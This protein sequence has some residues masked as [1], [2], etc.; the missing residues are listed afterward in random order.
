MEFSG[1][2]YQNGLPFPSLGG[3]PDPGIEP[4]SPALQAD[5]L[6]CEIP[7]MPYKCTSFIVTLWTVACQ[8]PLS[9]EFSKKEYW[10]ESSFP[11]PGDLPNSWMEPVSPVSPALAGRFST[12]APPGK[13]FIWYD[14]N[15]SL[16]SEIFDM[17]FFTI[18]LISKF[19]LV[20]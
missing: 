11:S 8:A 18:K 10:S 12:T 16:P 15:H 7:G 2:K 9:M 19:S 14:T 17:F 1:H 6:L 13:P 3:L 20:S 4:A 5:S